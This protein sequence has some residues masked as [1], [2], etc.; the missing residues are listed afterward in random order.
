MRRPASGC[1]S[2]QAS[3]LAQAH[4]L[5]DHDERRRVQAGVAHARLDV[6]QRTGDHALAGRRA[7]LDHGRRRLRRAALGD[8]A[9]A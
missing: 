1:E 2:C 7:A 3:A 4:D 9:L 5:A 8:Q 6:G